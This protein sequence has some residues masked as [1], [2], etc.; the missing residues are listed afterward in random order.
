MIQAATF[1]GTT[2]PA[3]AVRRVR[4]NNTALFSLIAFQVAVVVVGIS[5]LV[6]A[7]PTRMPLSTAPDYSL[8]R[9]AILDRANGQQLDP[10]VEVAYGVVAPASSVRGLALHGVTYYYYFEGQHNFDP[11]SRS[12]V[13]PNRAQIVLRDNAASAP[14]VIYTL[15]P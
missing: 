13:A 4:L 15:V 10:L 2:Q 12:L 3:R 7:L 1:V 5:L 14:L 9:S 11:L 6:H 8:V